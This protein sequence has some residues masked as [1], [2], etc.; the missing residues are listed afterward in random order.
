LVF[1]EVDPQLVASV[2]AEWTGIPEGK[3][4][5][6]ESSALALAG[7]RLRSRILG[8]DSALDAVEKA[9]IASYAGLDSPTRPTGAF[10]LVGPSGVGKTET[11]LAVAD[12]LFGGEQMLISINMSEF[13]EK[14]TISRLIGSPPGYVGYGEGGR[15][16]EAVRRRPYSVVLFDEVEKAHPDVMNLF[17]QIFDKGVLADGEGREVDFRNT[18]IFMTSNLGA[19]ITAALCDGD[20]TPGPEELLEALLPVLTVFFRP[21]LLGRMTVVPYV[22]IKPSAMRELV[23]KKLEQISERILHRHKLPLSWSDSLV[24][25]IVNSCSAVDT[26]AR[27]IDHCIN[28]NLLPNIAGVLLGSPARTGNGKKKLHIDIDPATGQFTCAML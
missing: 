10:L 23:L 27:N 28:A 6:T 7:R 26:G 19:D 17:Y 25:N 18:M 15:L 24:D 9:L 20:A 14:H 13:Q 8:Q 2:V 4:G 16:T 1:F 12:E 22:A 3:L 5:R 21:A 11:A